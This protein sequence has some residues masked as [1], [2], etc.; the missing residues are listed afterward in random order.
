MILAILIFPAIL[1]SQECTSL[2]KIVLLNNKP[3]SIS[4]VRA[5]DLIEGVIDTLYQFVDVYH[6]QP[7]RHHSF[8]EYKYISTSPPQEEKVELMR[9]IFLNKSTGKNIWEW[10]SEIVVRRTIIQPNMNVIA[11]KSACFI[12]GILAMIII[13]FSYYEHFN[14]RGVLIWTGSMLLV[15]TIL[16]YI[17]T[18]T[19]AFPLM[20]HLLGVLV[21]KTLKG[22]VIAAGALFIVDRLIRF[23]DSIRRKPAI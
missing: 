2:D 20:W 11:W 15:I 16:A 13:F 14:I 10:Q 17:F 23:V 22:M 18:A 3:S 21:V 9:K 19:P 8:V 7:H 6:S 12:L 5:R 1:S 4:E